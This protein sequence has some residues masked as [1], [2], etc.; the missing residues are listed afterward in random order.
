VI[1]T[2]LAV[3]F[4]FALARLPIPGKAA[5]L[6]L[7]ALPLV[8]P[9]FVSAYAIVLL[10]GRSGIVTQW[11]QSWGVGFGSIYGAGGIVL[12]YTLTLYPYVLCRPS[13]PLSGRRLHGR[14][15]ARTGSSPRRTV[16]TV[17]LPSCCPRCWPVRC[18][19]HRNPGEFGV[20]F[21]LA[22]D[23]PIFA[24][25]AF[26]LFIGETAPNPASAG[27]L[28]VLLIL[29]TALVLLVQ[30]R[31]CRPAASPPTR[32]RPRRSSR[33]DPGCRI[34]WDPR[35]AGSSEPS[36]SALLRR[37]ARPKSSG[38]VAG[39]C[40]R[41]T[42]RRCEITPECRRTIRLGPGLPRSA[43]RARGA[44]GQ[45]RAR[46]LQDFRSGAGDV[47]LTSE[48]EVI[49][50]RMFGHDYELVLPRSTLRIDNPVAVVDVYAEKH[51]VTEVARGF[52]EY[53]WTRDAQRAYAFLRFPSRR[54]DL[55]A[56]TSISIRGSRT[57]GRSRAR[58]LGAHLQG[59]VRCERHP[60]EVQAV[61][62]LPVTD[63]RPRQAPA[64]T[65][66]S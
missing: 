54:R 14:S 37:H 56:R 16:W 13:L 38:A 34:L 47:A 62:E 39:I 29:M 2:A 12:V 20:P 64:P 66:R 8:L 58:R 11:L 6:A 26:K 22:E 4:A 43:H 7:A 1:T 17:T 30:R 46:I 53:L 65:S 44:L 36:G 60:G 3:P 63:S 32:A 51:G 59:P 48:S 15:G 61:A 33:W 24:V 45:G 18:C 55:A 25:E 42:A 27:V 23:M 50:G 9:S 31:F 52:V 19:L 5:I 49:R 35:L 41:P 10:L 21:V 57:S 40:A 28:G